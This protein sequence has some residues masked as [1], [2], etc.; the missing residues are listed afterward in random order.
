M[1]TANRTAGDL[2]MD[3]PHHQGINDRMQQ[4]KD[5]MHWK[6]LSNA[7]SYIIYF[8][9]LFICFITMRTKIQNIISLLI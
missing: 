5:K 4:A 8:M 2:L 1:P 3:S 9:R 7:I 6:S